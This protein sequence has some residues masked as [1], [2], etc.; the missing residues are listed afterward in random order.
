[1]SFYTRRELSN[2]MDSLI[3][4][5][6]QK[7]G[8]IIEKSG[9]ENFVSQ[10][11]RGLLRYI[12]N[13]TTVTFLRYLPDLFAHANGKSFFIEL[14]VMDSPIKYQSRVN[15][16]KDL[17]GHKDLSTSNI[18]VVETASIYNYKKLTSIGVEI[19]LIVYCTFNNKFILAEWEK[20]IV[21]FY[22]DVVK[23]GEGNASFTPYT[24]IH[25]DKMRT[26]KELF[27]SD[28]NIHISKEIIDEIINNLKNKK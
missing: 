13:D 7:S 5:L 2:R 10:N 11:T 20:N 25:L 19:L 24:N 15:T 9:Y 28:F 12:H 26:L 22:N 4:N 8:F 21:T 14:K 3:V 18:G 23:I 1:M 27:L 6:F 17:S 16:L